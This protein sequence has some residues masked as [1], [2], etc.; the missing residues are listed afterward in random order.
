MNSLNFILTSIVICNTLGQCQCRS[1]YMNEKVSFCSIFI[2]FIS[3]FHEAI[4]SILSL[5][6]FKQIYLVF[7]LQT[8]L[9]VA[10]SETSS[11]STLAVLVNMIMCNLS[12]Q[13]CEDLIVESVSLDNLVSVLRWSGEAHGSA[14]VHRQALHFLREEF[15]QVISK[16]RNI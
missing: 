14:W 16:M 4:Y 6:F 13:G 15:S 10:F 1:S 8:H 12:H 3:I 5:S 9:C 11:L 7:C 2:S